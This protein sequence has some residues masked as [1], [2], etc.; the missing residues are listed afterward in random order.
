MPS[1]LQKLYDLHPDAKY[2]GFYDFANPV[3]LLRDTD[4]IKSITVK[5]F[6]TFSEHRSFADKKLDP[7]LGGMLFLL[8]GNEW[9]ETRTQLTPIFTS[10]KL[11]GMFSLMSDVAIRFTDYLYKKSEKE[12]ELEIKI[13]FTRYTNDL[14]ASCVFGVGVNSI[15]DPKNP[16]YVNGTI[17]TRMTGTLRFLQIHTLRRWRWLARLLNVKLIP[18]YRSKFF[19]DLIEDTMN[20]R[21]TKG[22]YRPD[23][24]QFLM[25]TKKKSQ[26]EGHSSTIDVPCHAFSF[27]FGGYDTVASQASL[28]VYNLATHPEIQERLQQ[29]IDQV[30]E[31]TQGQVTYDTILG[32]EYLDAVLNEAMRLHPTSIVLD[33]T[34]AKDFE[35]PPA[36]PGHKPFTI[37]KGMSV[38]IPIRA[39]Q[40]DP[41]NYED[42]DK[43]NPERFL[44]DGKKIVS[45]NKFFPFGAGPRGCIGS[46]FAVIEMK[47]LLF[48][49]YARLTIRP[50]SKTNIPFKV[51]KNALVLTSENG[52]W[53]N[54]K[55]REH[56]SPF[57]NSAVSNGTSK[58]E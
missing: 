29:E 57:L 12:Q 43:Y 23:M 31:K 54:V 41:K 6:E 39:V 34:C 40:N 28:T 36:L 4:I 32:M 10:S 38:W 58:T 21:D 33:R 22:I 24:L 8:T 48:H 13:W 37:K 11:K 52:F 44:Q 18:N 35:L 42:P 53:M 16:L 50:C 7:L 25:E 47:I 2:V 19:E 20:H 55:P 46:R 17:A 15:K 56:V 30:L 49:V 45:S 51:S 1:L 27:F 9:K 26:A 14:I 3:V 5:N